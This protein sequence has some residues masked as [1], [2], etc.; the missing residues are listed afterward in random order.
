MLKRKLP[1]FIL[2]AIILCLSLVHNHINAAGK[3][4]TS[5][6]SPN[7]VHE[8]PDSQG[9]KGK[10]YQLETK[11]IE[12]H[13]LS[14]SGLKG[15]LIIVDFWATWCPP[16]IAEVPHFVDLQNEYGPRGLQIVGI[17]LDDTVDP[18]KPFVSEYKVNYPII[19]G[20][21]EDLSSFGR[22]QGIPTTFI[23][24]RN[25]ELIAKVVGYRDKAYFEAIIKANI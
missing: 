3:R 23:F 18:V 4:P 10:V 2:S 11:T 16:C 14:F 7:Q 15:K 5:T 17:S 9:Q 25:Q 24:N 1:F 19:L 12:G 20:S 8:A 13:P 22:L 6:P 21:Q